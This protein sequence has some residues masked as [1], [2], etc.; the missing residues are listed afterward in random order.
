MNKREPRPP[1][2]GVKAKIPKANPAGGSTE[3][4]GVSAG[5]RGFETAPPAHEE[6]AGQ[7]G[8]TEEGRT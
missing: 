4:D 6:V 8:L 5:A 3:P 2:L 7:E 1:I